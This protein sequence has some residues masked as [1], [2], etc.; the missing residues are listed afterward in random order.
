MSPSPSATGIK[1]WHVGAG[2]ALFFAVVIGADASFVMLA[3]RTHPGQVAVRP[4]EDG[5]IYNTRL[6][7]QRA[8]AATGWRASAAA[9]PDE[10]VMW[11]RDREGRPV[12]GLEA[13]ATLQRPATERGSRRVTLVETE[14]GRYAGPAR[15]LSGA[16][17]VHLVAEGAEGRVFEA[18]RRLTWP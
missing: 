2:V 11:L 10:V 14:P 7:R 15:G 6:A 9:R 18:D 8:Q 16:W 3:Y 13:T 4:Y 1:G 12:M 5:L 17:D